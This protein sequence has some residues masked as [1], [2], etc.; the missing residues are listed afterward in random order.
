MFL[1]VDGISEITLPLGF[2][3]T[4]KPFWKHKCCCLPKDNFFNQR[5]N[6]HYGVHNLKEIWN[7]MYNSKHNNM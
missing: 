5:V 6:L 4:F 3:F 2:F 1:H 7:Y